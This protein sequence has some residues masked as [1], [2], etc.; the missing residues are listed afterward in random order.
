MVHKSLAITIPA[1]RII[2]NIVKAD[3]FDAQT[4]INSGIL[5]SLIKLIQNKKKIIRKEVCWTLS[6]ITLGPAEIVQ[7]CIDI[8]IIDLAI[9]IILN[10]DA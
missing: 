9:D 3:A 6:N 10:D 5:L 4:A 7:Q 8:G 1:I 2:G